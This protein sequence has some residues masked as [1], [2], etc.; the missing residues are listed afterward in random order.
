MSLKGSC[1][2]CRLT[3]MITQLAKRPDVMQRLQQ[4]QQE[5]MRKHGSDITGRASPPMHRA[6]DRL[7]LH[8]GTA[9]VELVR[10]TA[11]ATPLLSA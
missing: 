4:E 10:V 5:L 3:S 1:A 11:G 9:S 7:M 6:A 8:A 2:L